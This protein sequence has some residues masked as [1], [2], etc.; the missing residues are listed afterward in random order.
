MKLSKYPNYKDSGISFLG[1]IPS[2]W[3]VKRAKDSLLKIGSG[4]TPL[5]GSAVYSDIG[6]TFLRSQNVYDDRLRI[7]NVSY[8]SDEIF[9]KM[10]GSAIKANDILINLTGASI[11]RTCLVPKHLGKAN[12]NQHIAFLRFR[13][14]FEYISLFLKTDTFKKY[15]FSEQAGSSKE[16]FNLSQLSNLAYPLPPKAEQTAIANYLDTTTQALDKKVG[17][18]EQKIKYYEELKKAIINETVTKGLDKNVTLKD[19][20]VD[21]IGQIPQHWEVKRVKDL[22]TINRGR[23]IGQTELIEDGLYPVYSSQTENDGCLGYINTFDFNADVLT[24]TTDG[25]NAGTVFKRNGKFNCTNICGILKLFNNKQNLNYLKF[26][27]QESASHNKRIDTNGAKI[28]SNEMAIIKVP[29]PPL[30]EQTAI[31]EYLDTQ[32]NQI[33][34]IVQNLQ[35]Q[36][37]KQKELR[38]SLINEVVTGKVKVY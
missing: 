16:A 26:A 31:A 25:A 32:T 8:I 7:A 35:Q 21:Y 29:L 38:K 13:K 22:F 11:G 28:M 37:E 30:T 24:W 36:I 5:G 19:S 34:L 2:H 20:G 18:L 33:D 14:N 12:I 9:Q 23:V 15:L 6:I 10:K 27:L 17:L 4:V 3:E 1:N